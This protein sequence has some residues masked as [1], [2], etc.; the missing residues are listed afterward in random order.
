MSDSLVQ[1]SVCR[2]EE[3]FLIRNNMSFVSTAE[4][5]FLSKY[6]YKFCNK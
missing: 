4:L 5:H 2:Y 3:G 6:E 1:W